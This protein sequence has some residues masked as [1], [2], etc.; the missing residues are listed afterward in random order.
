MI[1]L[2]AHEGGDYLD[3]GQYVVKTAEFEEVESDNSKGVKVTFLNYLEKK[4]NHAFWIFDKRTNQASKAI[5]NFANFC[6][7]AGVSEA[8]RKKFN[9]KDFMKWCIE[10]LRGKEVFIDVAKNT[11][12]YHEV[13][14]IFPANELSK[15]Y[16]GESSVKTI[17]GP[18]SKPEP[19]S[20]DELAKEGVPDKD[21]PF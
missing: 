20:A 6:K 10:H 14:G 3:E 5:W 18:E 17:P 15:E 16:T 12:G 13:V 7:A 19:E 4:A 11:D 1:D 21:V 9:E 2:T 8:A